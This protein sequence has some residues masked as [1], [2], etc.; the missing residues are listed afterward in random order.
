MRITQRVLHALDDLTNEILLR[1]QHEIG[2]V[3][4]N[5]PQSSLSMT[6]LEIERSSEAQ[7]TTRLDATF[8]AERVERES[9]VERALQA[10]TPDQRDALFLHLGKGMTC[11]EIAKQTGI[12]RASVLDDLVRAYAH[13]R[14]VLDEANRDNAPGFGAETAR[15]KDRVRPSRR[16]RND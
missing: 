1:L 7:A 14:R 5:S 2:D 16:K 6:L 11:A 9:A 13:I 3:A 4:D 8:P 15:P 10:L 12:P